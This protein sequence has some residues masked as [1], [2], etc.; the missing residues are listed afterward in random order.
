MLRGG[1]EIDSLYGGN[2]DDV[3]HCGLDSDT[4]D[5]GPHV[6]G[7]VLSSAANDGCELGQT[8]DAP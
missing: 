3:L 4:A 6:N 5:G 2:T 7:D 8:V 1:D